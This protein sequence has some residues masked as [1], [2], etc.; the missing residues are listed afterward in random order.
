MVVKGIASRNRPSAASASPA[1]RRPEARSSSPLANGSSRCWARAA[2][3]AARF[4]SSASSERAE[5]AHDPTPEVER[6]GCPPF[7]MH[8]GHVGLECVQGGQRLVHPAE[9]GQRHGGHHAPVGVGEP[10][11][12]QP[13]SRLGPDQPEGL[14]GPA[15][16][17]PEP[18]QPGLGH[19]PARLRGRS[20]RPDES[21]LGAGEVA[22]GQGDPP[23]EGQAAGAEVRIVGLA[24]PPVGQGQGLLEVPLV[25][26]RPGGDLQ[27]LGSRARPAGHLEVVAGQGVPRGHRR[28][29]GPFQ[30][31]VDRVVQ[32][33]GLVQQAHR[34]VL[35][36]PGDGQAGRSRPAWWRRIRDR[37]PAG[38]DGRRPAGRRGV[39]RRGPGRPAGGGRRRGPRRR[40]TPSPH[41]SARGR[42]RRPGPPPPGSGGAPPPPGGRGAWTGRWRSRR[43]AGRGR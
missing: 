18:R 8:G 28:H 39:G 42:R 17:H 25:V 1:R 11:G 43:P 34:L 40:W 22:G 38:H 27:G 10:V 15:L 16:V 21:D 4:S 26:G 31:G 19:A 36:E 20:D 14:P 12:G 7:R 9:H 29:P 35:V 37:H 33:H 23:P 2:S 3:M 5:V 32:G 24:G 13:P 6:A 30:P 41:G